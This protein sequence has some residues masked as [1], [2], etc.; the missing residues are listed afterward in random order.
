MKNYKLHVPE[1]FSDTVGMKSLA[2][3]EIEKRCY[4]LYRLYGYTPIE[5]PEVEYIDVFSFDGIQKPDLYNLIN[6]QGEVLALRNDMTSSIARYVASNPKVENAVLKYSYVADV[7]RYPRLYQGKNHQFK[8]VG[9]EL[10]GKS[11]EYCDVEA[12]YLA[13]KSLKACN[14][15]NF[16][17][18][19]GSQK[20]LDT[21]FTDFGINDDLKQKLFESIEAKDYVT[22]K[23][24]LNDTL[25]VDKSKFIIDLM[26]RGG[27]LRFIE[28][29]MSN[30]KGKESYNVL[31]YLKKIFI[32]LKDLDI[33][34]VIFD[35]SIYSYAKYYTGIIFQVYVDKV[36]KAVLSGGRSDSLY[37]SFG[38]DLEDIGFGLEIDSLAEYVLENDLIDLKKVKYLSYSDANSFVT[39]TIN[40]ETFRE[41][42]IIVSDGHFNSLEDATKYAKENDYDAVIEY[43]N[44]KIRLW[45]VK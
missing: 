28:S 34:N 26:L 11:N 37:K 1:G 18:H 21:L 30:L 19:L 24:I 20:F 36:K 31:D 42:G 25:D 41:D 10:I 35:F 7:F 13:Y 9:I 6:R 3:K 12:I 32:M 40:N 33:T 38:K 27:H 22:L 29:L 5:T 15:N 45:E 43:S 39:A 4:E 16:T 44:N 2:K 17:I 23:Q 14:V 8:Q